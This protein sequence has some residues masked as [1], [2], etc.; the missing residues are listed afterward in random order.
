MGLHSVLKLGGRDRGSDLSVV[1]SNGL[2]SFLIL[3]HFSSVWH[4]SSLTPY[5]SFLA[6]SSF[7]LARLL[8]LLCLVSHILPALQPEVYHRSVFEPLLLCLHSCLGGFYTDSQIYLST[9]NLS[10]RFRLFVS[11]RLHS[12]PIWR[13]C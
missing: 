3:A 2:F 1:R 6:S 8:S 12:G 10:T 9:L 4:G 11:S 7:T 13:H 5:F